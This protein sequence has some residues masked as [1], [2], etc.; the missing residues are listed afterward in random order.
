VERLVNGLLGAEG[1]S[2]IDLSRNLAGDDLEDLLAELDEEVVERRV[3]LLLDR[4]TLRL[5][6]GHRGIQER[7]V[8]GLLGGGQDQGGVCGRILGLVLA[9]GCEIVSKSWLSSACGAGKRV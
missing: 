3:D 9:D 6:L 4:A 5:G 8:L 1:E 7:G 2:G